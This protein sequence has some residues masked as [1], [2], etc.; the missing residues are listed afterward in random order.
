MTRLAFAAL[1][2]LATALPA[3][4]VAAQLPAAKVGAVAAFGF[5]DVAEMARRE[6]A[7]AYGRRR[8]RPCRPS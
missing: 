3:A 4:P 2:C 5:D 8:R 1:L 6:A 7:S